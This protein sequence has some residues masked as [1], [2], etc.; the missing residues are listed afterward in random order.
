MVIILSI[1]CLIIFLRSPRGLSHSPWAVKKINPRCNDHYQSMYQKRLIDEAKILKNLHHPNI[2]GKF[3]FISWQ[4]VCLFRNSL[5]NLWTSVTN[6]NEDGGGVWQ[7][8]GYCECSK[9]RLT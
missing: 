2:V 3:K 5:Y 1:H 8:P 4:Y 7:E 9:I 6:K